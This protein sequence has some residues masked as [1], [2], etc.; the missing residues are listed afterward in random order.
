MDNKQR[1]KQITKTS[2]IGILTNL[3]LVAFK[4]IAGLLSGSI[5]IILDA[6]NNLTDALSSVITILGIKLAKRKPDDKHPFGFGRIEYFSTILI[7]FMVLF[8]GGTSIVESVKKI[9]SPE[10]PDYTVVTIVIVVASVVTKLGLGR[11][12]SSQ[13]EKYNS[14]ALVASGADASFDAIIS[15]STLL[16]AVAAYFFNISID[17]YLGAV[18]SCFIIKA[19]LEM[20][21]GSLSDII[22]NRPDSEITKEIKMTAASIPNVMG[23][24][25]LVLHNYGPDHQVGS[26]HVEVPATLDGYQIHHIITQIQDVIMEKFH[27]FMTVGIYAVDESDGKAE[28]REVIRDTVTAFDGVVNVH[29]IYISKEDKDI[30]FDTTINF[31]VKDKEHLNNMIIEALTEKLPEYKVNVKFDTNY[32]D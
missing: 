28:M 26:I 11:F 1:E 23:A 13:G 7:S 16:G 20:L 8:A 24:Y 14:D 5:A 3:C 19:G 15:A 17:G 12:V 32:S 25:D 22:G 21:F 18:I 9:I 10:M 2:I 30:R 31:K 29:G 27:I 4:A 6:L